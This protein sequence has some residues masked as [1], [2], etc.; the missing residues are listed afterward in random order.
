MEEARKRERFTMFEGRLSVSQDQNLAW[1]VLQVPGSLD[2]GSIN[3]VG[4]WGADHASV[5]GSARREGGLHVVA[6]VD[7]REKARVAPPL[8][9][10]AHLRWRLFAHAD[11]DLY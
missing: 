8:L 5:A 11:K 3:H 10:L 6:G 9:P 2:S 1:T 4:V 7:R